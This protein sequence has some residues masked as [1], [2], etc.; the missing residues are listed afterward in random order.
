MSCV[1]FAEFAIFFNF[2]AIGIVLFVFV[3]LVIPLFAFRAG[4]RN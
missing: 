3:G 2:N 4:Q 1:F